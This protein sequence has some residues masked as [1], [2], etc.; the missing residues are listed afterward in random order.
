MLVVRGQLPLADAVRR[1]SFAEAD[2]ACAAYLADG[3]PLPI[4]APA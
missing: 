2:A 1:V 4:A 3:G